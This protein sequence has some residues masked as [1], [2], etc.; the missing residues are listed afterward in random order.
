MLWRQSTRVFSKLLLNSGLYNLNKTH[1]VTAATHLLV[2]YGSSEIIAINITKIKGIRDFSVRYLF[3]RSILFE[4]LYLLKSLFKPLSLSKLV[5]FRLFITYLHKFT[6]SRLHA[7]ISLPLALRVYLVYQ[8][9][10]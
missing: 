3:R 9:V 2:P 1:S 8:K 7:L 6:A 4:L 10:K 5:L